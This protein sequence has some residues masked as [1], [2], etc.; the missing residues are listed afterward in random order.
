MNQSINDRLASNEARIAQQLSGGLNRA[1][2]NQAAMNRAGLASS[3][4]NSRG[5]TVLTGD[6]ARGYY[7]AMRTASMFGDRQRGADIYGRKYER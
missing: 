2:V 1:P 6:A 4:A 3:L 5:A 7:D